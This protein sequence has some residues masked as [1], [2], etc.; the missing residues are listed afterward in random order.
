MRTRTLWGFGFRVG[1]TR[2]GHQ[3]MTVEHKDLILAR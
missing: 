2:F 3:E 1:Q